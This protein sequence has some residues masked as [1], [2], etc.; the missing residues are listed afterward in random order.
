M[1]LCINTVYPVTFSQQCGLNTDSHL[2]V[3][4]HN[5]CPHNGIQTIICEQEVSLTFFAS[6]SPSSLPVFSLPWSPPDGKTIWLWPP[7]CFPRSP[8]GSRYGR[9]TARSVRLTGIRPTPRPG[10]GNRRDSVT[11]TVCHTT[12]SIATSSHFLNTFSVLTIRTCICLHIHE[13]K[14]QDST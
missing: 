13:Y 4:C 12:H 9:C 5:R 1:M 6:F 7:C 10:T 3:S 11:G 14:Y 2:H 8:T